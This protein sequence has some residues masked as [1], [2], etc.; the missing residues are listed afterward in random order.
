MSVDILMMGPMRPIEQGLLEPD[1]TLHR[2]WQ[3]EDKAAFLK[4]V[5]PRIRGAVAYS[6]AALMDAAIFAALPKLEIVGNMGVG[7]DSIDTGIAGQRGIIVTNA[8]NANE[9]DVG[10]HAFALVLAVGRAVAAGDRYVRAGRW[11]KEGRMAIT[12]RVSG[13][14]LG[15]LGMGHIGLEVARHAANFRMPVFYH[16]RTRRTDVDCTYVDSAVELARQV[17]VLVVA[18]PGGDATRHLVDRAVIEALGPDGV[19]VNI[20]RGTVID[21][22]AM[23]EALTQGKL[24]GAGLDVFEDEPNVPEAL[25]DH[26]HVVLQPHQGGA[27]YEGIAAAVGIL[28]ENM[29]NHFTGKPVINRVV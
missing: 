12:Q 23:V 4:E 1:F 15:I 11:V 5:G 29:K 17:D 14:K 2:L 7:Y 25:F 3:H 13:R 19:I 21:Q 9:V 20:A 16:N 10:E 26:P 18:A 6:G 8:G 24:A 27:T 28:I 22:A